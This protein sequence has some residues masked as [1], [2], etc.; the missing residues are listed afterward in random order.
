MAKEDSFRISH[1]S[2]TNIR[3]DKCT[4]QR[5]QKRSLFEA[6]ESK[7]QRAKVSIAGL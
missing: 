2:I 5:L 7:I 3:N 6:N 4:E 1:K